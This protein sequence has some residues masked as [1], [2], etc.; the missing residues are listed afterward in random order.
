M[1]R[2]IGMASAETLLIIL[3]VFLTLATVT[4]VARVWVKSVQMHKHAVDDGLIYA[5]LVSAR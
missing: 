3:S 2:S 5:S 4:V 1:V